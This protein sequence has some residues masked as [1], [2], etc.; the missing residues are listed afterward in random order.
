MQLK[1]L[2]SPSI[3]LFLFFLSSPSLCLPEVFGGVSAPKLPTSS[4]LPA[5]ILIGET[6]GGL[7]DSQEREVGSGERAETPQSPEAAAMSTTCMHCARAQIG[8]ALIMEGNNFLYSLI[9]TAHN[10]T[11]KV[12]QNSAVI[13]CQH[14]RF[15]EN[16]L[17]QTVAEHQCMSGLS[18]QSWVM[19]MV[20]FVFCHKRYCCNSYVALKQDAKAAASSFSSSWWAHLLLNLK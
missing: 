13:I 10:L 11:E 7:W 6:V 9:K 18:H 5:G 3:P 2:T 8:G 4:G 15:G 12:H 16:K 1:I 14:E 20:F 19:V 17:A